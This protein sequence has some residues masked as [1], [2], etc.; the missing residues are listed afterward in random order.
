MAG[1]FFTRHDAASYA[2]YQS[3]KQ[4]ARSQRR[5]LPGAP[6]ILKRRTRGGTE[7]WAREFNRPD[8]RKADEHI[9][10]VAAVAPAQLDRIRGEME[11]AKALVSESSALRLFG[12]QRVERKVAAVLG[13]LFSHGLFSAGLTLVGS[14]AYE[15][16]VNELGI[17]VRKE[18]EMAGNRALQLALPGGVDFQ[19]ILADS[20]L[21]FVPV[22]GMPSRQP[23]GSFKLPGADAL[24]VD[25]LV[26]GK[27]LGKVV[28]LAELR[29]HA[30]EVPL[31][32]FLLEGSIETIALGPNHV[33]PV[34]VPAP[35]RFVVHK[36]MSSQARKTERAKTRKDLD[37]AAA[38][39]AVLTED[40]PGMLEDAFRA[41]PAAGRGTAKRGAAA[42]AMLLADLH[43][44]ASETLKRIARR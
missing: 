40:S 14:H 5:V 3:V 29:T 6:G 13:A 15:S 4:L 22:P 36:L 27:T 32:G 33:V 16:L 25:M 2:K 28:S 1:R 18:V 21:E 24:S 10:T 26:P 37:Q 31:L 42:A 35:E 12:Y 20:G 7:Y 43:P 8:G 9:G 19:R 23:S 38:L 30:Q 39:A 34:R 11:L 41:F 44:A 17:A